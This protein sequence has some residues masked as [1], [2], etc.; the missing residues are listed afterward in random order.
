LLGPRIA[1]E[2]ALH[3]ARGLNDFIARFD[4]VYRHANGV[5]GVD[6]AAGDA[7]ANPP[8]RVG[9]KAKTETVVEFFH[10]PHQAQVAFLHQV[11]KAQA[12]VCVLF[13]D[14]HDQ[15]QIGLGE[16]LARGFDPRLA[17]A[18]AP[19]LLF[20]LF[21]GKAGGLFDQTNFAEG[22][23]ALA[24]RLAAR[25]G[26]ESAQA[27]AKAGQLADGALDLI[28]G[29]TQ[30]FDRGK[31]LRQMKLVFL[32]QAMAHRLRK[33]GAAQSAQDSVPLAHQAREL[34]DLLQKRLG[35]EHALALVV[36]V[37]A[38]G[39]QLA[40]LD[41][42]GRE[43]RRQRFD[44]AQREGRGKKRLK[45]LLGRAF[46]L[47][48]QLDL[49]LAAQ[50]PHRADVLQI[51]LHRA[52]R[53]IVLLLFDLLF[54]GALFGDIHGGAEVLLLFRKRPDTEIFIAQIFVGFAFGIERRG[55]RFS[56]YNE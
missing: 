8:G 15:P 11:E 38:P 21:D 4:S 44:P 36:L 42:A 24:P 41:L 34:A 49:A 3:L 47:L 32:P 37:I 20:K 26:L 33:P 22:G 25:L 27:F 40:Q 18:D 50:Q 10:R 29:Q 48:R 31:N 53:G 5:A 54:V 17:L 16:F 28:L 51:L 52:E 30:R 14:A 56:P 45:N 1:A 23:F 12:A 55:H 9:G 39:D 2:L 19:D 7:L 6:Q 46:D 35:I 13:R 43:S